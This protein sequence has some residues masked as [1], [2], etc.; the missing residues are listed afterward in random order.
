MLSR[1]SLTGASSIFLLA[2][3]IASVGVSCLLGSSTESSLMAPSERGAASF[4]AVGA[5]SCAASGCHGAPREHGVLGSEYG[6]WAT[7]DRHASAYSVLFDERS[8][9][10]EAAYS[11]KSPK[12]ARAEND[13]LCLRCHGL[14]GGLARPE[15]QSDGV[16]CE[17]CHG[18]AKAWLNQHY[19]ANWVDRSA[20][21]KA[22]L[23]FI[24]TRDLLQRGKACAAC[25]VGNGTKEVNHDL[26]AAG[27]PRL[28]FEYSAYLAMEVKHWDVAAE[29]RRYPDLEIRTWALGQL[30]SAQAALEL[31]ATRAEDESATRTSAGPRPWPEFAE[32]D[33]FACH[34]DLKSKSWR[35]SERLLADQL[36]GRDVPGRQ[37]GMLDWGSW[38][39]AQ[40][41]NALAA[42]RSAQREQIEKTI[43]T[44]H[45]LMG[46]TQNR[47]EVATTARQ[48]A[49]MLGK[50][51]AI[52]AR[53]PSDPQALNNLVDA[54]LHPN[55]NRAE[56]TWDRATQL[57]LGL[58]A[59]VNVRNDRQPNHIDH[60][61]QERVRAIAKLLQFPGGP[62]DALQF[63]SPSAFNPNHVRQ[64]FR[65]LEAG[66]PK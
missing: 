56:L 36:T 40:L 17:S 48:A 1:R 28:Q 34:H 59:A 12:E 49:A 35:A 31:L 19:L 3:G 33:C 41:P 16:S 39:T 44:V 60:R 20:A 51:A 50:A 27:H 54:L 4:Q 65:D 13:Q 25:H 2:C 37:P 21:D 7:F 64:A 47:Q 43:H 8:K 38:Y 24:D 55:D 6:I 58:A 63:D 9:Q 10:I 61:F 46:T 66:A 18:P 5:G 30:L 11:H 52:L 14:E 57:Y 42:S 23:G 29:K 15:L 26:V 45:Q 22:A 62:K 53:E 32:Y